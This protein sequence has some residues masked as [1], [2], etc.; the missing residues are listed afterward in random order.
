MSIL[1]LGLQHVSIKQGDMPNWAEKKV[2][3]AST[4]KE[5][6][7]AANKFDGL[8]SIQHE[9]PE[10]WGCQSDPYHTS[11][12]LYLWKFLLASSIFSS[13]I[14]QASAVFEPSQTVESVRR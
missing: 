9:Y 12:G 11:S 4:I 8:D 1:N 7:A 10:M 14:K 2:Q 6:R 3:S 13:K 5:I